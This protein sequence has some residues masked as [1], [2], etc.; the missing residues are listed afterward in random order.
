MDQ[1]TQIP[2]LI[3]LEQDAFWK[4]VRTIIREEIEKA[5][6]K[7]VNGPAVFHTEG[8]TE[9]P[10]FKISEVCKLFA[11]SRPTIYDWIKHGK[12]RPFKI[13]SRVYFLRNDIQDLLGVPLERP[14]KAS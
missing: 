8:L 14:A 1:S 12:L 2:I 5:D 7:T 11:V 10:L 9:K 3:P 6:F 4:Q 13:R